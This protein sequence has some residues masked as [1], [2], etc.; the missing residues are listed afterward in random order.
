MIF[1]NF[2]SLFQCYDNIEGRKC[3]RCVEN[4]FDRQR[5]CINCPPCY[6]LVKD[7]VDSHRQKLQSLQYSISNISSSDSISLDADFEDKMKSVRNKVDKLALDAKGAT[8]TG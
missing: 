7:A 6:N 5:G 8:G 3:D 1:G 2:V 4:K